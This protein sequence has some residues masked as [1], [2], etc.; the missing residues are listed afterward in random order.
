MRIATLP[1]HYCDIC[2]AEGTVA[3]CKKSCDID[4]CEVC[5]DI[6][7]D[8][9]PDAFNR[10]CLATRPTRA[11]IS[12][13]RASGCRNGSPTQSKALRL[14]RMPVCW[15][16]HF[17]STS[18]AGESKPAAAHQAAWPQVLPIS[19]GSWSPPPP[20]PPPTP[21][22][23]SDSRSPARTGPI[24]VTRVFAAFGQSD[25]LEVLMFY[26][27]MAAPI[28]NDIRSR[29]RLLLAVLPTRTACWPRGTCCWSWASFAFINFMWRSQTRG[30]SNKYDRC[31]FFCNS[32]VQSI[33]FCCSP[34]LTAAT[35]RSTLA[36]ASTYLP[37]REGTRASRPGV[38][39]C[40][41]YGFRSVAHSRRSVANMR[42]RG[43][44][45]IATHQDRH[46]RNVLHDGCHRLPV[47]VIH[48]LLIKRVLWYNIRPLSEHAWHECKAGRGGRRT[49]WGSW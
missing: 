25:G 16:A 11:H 21:T 27:H 38:K 17:V 37:A 35:N 44:L 13:W 32:P 31:L 26:N 20:P 34:T 45:G 49:L 46:W 12:Y 3:C 36:L 19:V 8:G 48:R 30:T 29:L 40:V 10:V 39:P 9:A 33:E 1:T 42:R 7:N 6:L 18:P 2:G 24:V 28:A 22:Q 47:F 43:A 15:T 4:Y 14:Q 5:M 41:A 23:S